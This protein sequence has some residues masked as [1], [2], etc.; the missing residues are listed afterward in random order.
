MKESNQFINED[1]YQTLTE[2]K[3]DPQSDQKAVIPLWKDKAKE[4][5]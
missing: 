3:T 4:K 2:I 5:K 1:T